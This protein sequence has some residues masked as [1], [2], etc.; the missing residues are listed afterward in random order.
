MLLVYVTACT[1]SIYDL[2]FNEL[3]ILKVLRKKDM[4]DKS[5]FWVRENQI[6][7]RKKNFEIIL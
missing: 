2:L 6:K 7:A 5:N 3:I 4:G 1:C